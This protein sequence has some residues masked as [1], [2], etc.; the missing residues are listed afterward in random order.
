MNNIS[1][2][3]FY[4]ALFWLGLFSCSASASNSWYQ[5]LG[6]P[7]KVGVSHIP[8]QAIYDSSGALSGM[9]ID[10]Y[11]LIAK[12]LDIE[13]E[14]VKYDSWNHLLEAA[15]KR[16]V[17]IVFVAQKNDSRKIF[18][19]F[20]DSFIDIDTYIIVRSDK[21]KDQSIEDY[22]GKIVAHPKGSATYDFFSL[23]YSNVNNKEYDNA[24][25]ILSMLSKGDID[26][27][28]M[29]APLVSYH[30]KSLGI[31]NLQIVRKTEYSYQLSLASRNDMPQIKELLNLGLSKI[32]DS[33]KHSLLLKWGFVHDSKV[34]MTFLFI[35]LP[36]L[37]ILMGL[38]VYIFNNN[39][40]LKKE[41]LKRR[42]IEKLL[43]KAYQEL[44]VERRKAHMEARTDPLT[45]I[46]NRRM[47]FEQLNLCWLQF[48]RS[49]K[50]FA[51]IVFDLDYFKNINDSYGH[52]VGD[53]VLV[54]VSLDVQ[55]RLRGYDSFGRL[56]GEEFA[57]LLP[58]T[59]LDDSIMVANDVKSV[60]SNYRNVNYPLLS[61]TASFAVAQIE[62][63][64][65]VDEFMKR[66][67]EALYRSKNDGRD[68]ITII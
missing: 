16:E 3:I 5:E 42:K 64:E 18:L 8:P 7:L 62:A 43:R 12:E 37:F 46:F 53:D 6:R 13:F 23:M 57:V 49:A 38:M 40:L 68:R 24:A 27:A 9:A 48:Q 14:Y 56:G 11:S 60:I 26:A 47:F 50:P 61:L 39:R 15:A 36:V 20:S 51:L 2:Y 33:H 67:D 30:M 41:V 19:D 29:E 35:A 22:H 52:D 66:L 59:T 45:G 21:S 34:D 31:D 63:H 58:A 4:A 32:G 17:D 28:I 44:E 25:I 10:Y 54:R 1:T 65:T 55:E